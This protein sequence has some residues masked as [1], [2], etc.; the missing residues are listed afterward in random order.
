MN[1]ES[2]TYTFVFTIV[3]IVTVALGLSLTAITL[4]PAQQRNVE[5]E[6]MQ[7]ILQSVNVRVDFKEAEKIFKKYITQTYLVRPDGSFSEGNAFGINLKEE[8]NKPVSE[9]QLPLY[10]AEKEGRKYY[11]IP[12]YGK[13]LWGPIWGYVALEDD[14]NTIYGVSFGHKG[15][16]PGLGAEI[17]KDKFKKRFVGKKIFDENGAFVSVK[18]E[19]GIKNPG[20]HEVDALSGATI[21][22]KGVEAMLHDVMENYV[23]FFKKNKNHGQ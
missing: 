16:T 6:K 18:V 15:E 13:G 8:L 2:N 23:N 3:M 4:K 11:I 1:K 20:L 10:V 21:T 12:L 22:S 17:V 9:R 7:N 5:L 19:K 14:M